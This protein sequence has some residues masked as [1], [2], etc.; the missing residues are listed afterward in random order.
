MLDKK[1]TEVLACDKCGCTWMTYLEVHRISSSPAPLN[2]PGRPIETH[3]VPMCVACGHVV[4][5]RIDPYAVR[6]SDYAA[7]MDMLKEVSEDQTKERAAAKT[8]RIIQ[9]TRPSWTPLYDK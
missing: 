1:Q 8:K 2:M 4:T 9:K 3:M 5:P 7:F 6:H